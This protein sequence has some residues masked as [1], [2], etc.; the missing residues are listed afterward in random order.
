MYEEMITGFSAQ[1]HAIVTSGDADLNGIPSKWMLLAMPGKEIVFQTL[2]YLLVAKQVC[3][4]ISFMA[5]ADK[6]EDTLPEFEKVLT[7]FKLIN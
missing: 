5:P 2:Q 4:Y 1:G 7:S 3:Y 6:F